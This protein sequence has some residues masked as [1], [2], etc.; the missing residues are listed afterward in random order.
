MDG[1]RWVSFGLAE[2]RFEGVVAFGVETGDA[3]E[4]REPSVGSA[5]TVLRA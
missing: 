5:A 3:R 1:S 2:I 4:F